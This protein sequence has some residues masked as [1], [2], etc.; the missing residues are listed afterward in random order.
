MT[1]TDVALASTGAL[2]APVAFEL[3]RVVKINVYPTEVGVISWR[4][5]VFAGFLSSILNSFFQ[6]LF[7]EGKFPIQDTFSILTRFIIGDV[8][9]LVVVLL[10]LVG[11]LRV[12]RG[13]SNV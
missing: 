12:F 7:L 5:L 4:T 10:M 13:Y 11:L 2:C 1:L 3:M 8:L 9:G 6:T